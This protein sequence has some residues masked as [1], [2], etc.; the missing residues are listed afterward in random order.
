MK[1]YVDVYNKALS[2]L[3]KYIKKTP[4]LAVSLENLKTKK[5]ILLEQN[6]G[7]YLLMHPCKC[8]SDCKYAS[9]LLMPYLATVPRDIAKLYPD[10]IKAL[11]VKESFTVDDYT[12]VLEEIR[13]KF[14]GGRL[15]QRHLELALE[16]VNSCIYGVC[17]ENSIFAI[18]NFLIPNADGILCFL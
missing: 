7:E 16:L 17:Q 1:L 8:A 18:G 2:S 5:C 10:L 6:D 15:D 12:S 11:G 13:Q 14:M 4:D 9:G 3:N